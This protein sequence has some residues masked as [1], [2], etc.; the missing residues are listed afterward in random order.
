MRRGALVCACAGHSVEDGPA[1][2]TEG[3]CESGNGRCVRRTCRD[4]LAQFHLKR[5]ANAPDALACKTEVGACPLAGEECKLL[6]CID[7][8]IGSF[9]DGRVEMIGR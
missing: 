7:S 2:R 9:S 4:E 6:T 5:C 1:C 8:S 3:T